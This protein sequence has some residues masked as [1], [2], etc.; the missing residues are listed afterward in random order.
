MQS[1]DP[2]SQG[3]VSKQAVRPVPDAGGSQG[4]L[5]SPL[6]WLTDCVH[7]CKGHTHMGI[8]SFLPFPSAIQI[9]CA[10]S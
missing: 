6:N 1:G 7:A 3:P 5:Q 10:G 8:A 4:A 2:S 9:P